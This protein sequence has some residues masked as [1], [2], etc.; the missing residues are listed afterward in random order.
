MVA[1]VDKLD[2]EVDELFKLF[3]EN[4]KSKLT[5]LENSFQNSIEKYLKHISWIYFEKI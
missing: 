5:E 1:L 4:L 2:E 3:V